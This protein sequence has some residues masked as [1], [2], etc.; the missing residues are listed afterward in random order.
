MKALPVVVV[1]VVGA[2][3]MILFVETVKVK[4]HVPVSPEVSLTVP[5]AL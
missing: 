3:W 1:A 2:S 5:V 4:L